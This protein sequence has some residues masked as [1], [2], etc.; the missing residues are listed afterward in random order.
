MYGDLRID[1]PPRDFARSEGQ[2]LTEVRNA[3]DCREAAV[4]VQLH[5]IHEAR[6]V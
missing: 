1:I 4:D 3:L 5:P 6:I 2:A